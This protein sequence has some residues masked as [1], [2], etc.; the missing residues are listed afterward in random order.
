[1]NSKDNLDAE[2]LKGGLNE[3]PFSKEMGKQSSATPRYASGLI[4][5]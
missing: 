4:K 2:L 3:I 1:M 5:E